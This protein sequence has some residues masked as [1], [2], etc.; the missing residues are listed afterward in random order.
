MATVEAPKVLEQVLEQ[1]L[2]TTSMSVQGPKPRNEDEC[3][4]AKGENTTILI[5]ADGHGGQDGKIAAQ[6]AVE[7]FRNALEKIDQ[8][9]IPEIRALLTKTFP[10]AHEAI[11]IALIKNGHNRSS[12]DQGSVREFDDSAVHGGTTFTVCITKYD[13]ETKKT[14][15]I[16]AYV[17]DSEAYLIKKDGLYVEL[18]NVD[19][20]P[21]SLSE[22]LRLKELE[23][24]RHETK[25][26]RPVAT[27]VYNTS[28]HDKQV[29]IID[30]ATQTWIM[31]PKYV[32]DP[33]SN[34]L[35]P[36]N[37]RYETGA[38]LYYD[39]IGGL[40][41]TTLLAMTRSLGDFYA[42]VVGAI[43]EPS[44]SEVEVKDGDTIIVA[45]DGLWDVWAYADFAKFVSNPVKLVQAEQIMKETQKRARAAFGS[46][47][48]D[49]TVVVH[50]V[51]AKADEP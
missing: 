9:S 29:F 26:T 21:K 24:L 11:R 16:T 47:H 4:I 19:H 22:W 1:V 15:V 3:F 43:C 32:S 37:V 33:W 12:D 18:T 10:E 51:Q 23:R 48:D 46:Q 39:S 17:G 28:Q 27:C 20:S 49:V 8:M 14:S 36:A 42:H 50:N 31:D 34:G 6:V 35:H 25:D 13:S 44:V 30:G 38:Y 40:D 5:V 41:V 45:S 7:F 2:D